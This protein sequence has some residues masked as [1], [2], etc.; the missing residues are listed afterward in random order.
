MWT[1]AKFMKIL[2]NSTIHL[3]SNKHQIT[4]VSNFTAQFT[5][6]LNFSDTSPSDIQQLLKTSNL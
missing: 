2:S 1:L 6:I 3:L 4:W 5:V